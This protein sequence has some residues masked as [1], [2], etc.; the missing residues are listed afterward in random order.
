[1]QGNIIGERLKT[2]RESIKCSQYQMVKL[3]GSL[4]QP[5]ITRYEKGLNL[6][7]CDV[8]LWYANYFD[9][10]L[11]YIFGRTDNPRGKLFDC[12]P[13]IAEKNEDLAE[14]IEMCFDPKSPVNARLKET[15]LKMLEE[16]KKQ[17]RN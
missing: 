10:S 2:L 1:M 5:A 16:Q 7:S 3:I 11:D 15:M 13:K 6:P 12:K 17:M 8:L 9:V 4:A 14:F